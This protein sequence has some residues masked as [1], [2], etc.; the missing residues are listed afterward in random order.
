MDVLAID[1]KKARQSVKALYAHIHKQQP[2][3]PE[4]VWLMVHTMRDIVRIRESPL[5]IKHAI[6]Q[7][8][9]RRCLFSRDPQQKIKDLLAQK[10]AKG[11]HNVIGLS[12]FRKSQAKELLDKYDVFLADKRLAR[13]LSKSL[14]KFYKECRPTYIDLDQPDLQKEIIRVVHTTLMDYRKGSTW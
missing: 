4:A 12:K 8:G 6:Q 9:T 2:D 13:V 11:I 5:P 7:A 3:Q 14:G 1:E 10:K